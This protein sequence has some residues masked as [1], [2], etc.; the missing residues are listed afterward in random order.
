[1][2]N[3]PALAASITFSFTGVVSDVSPSL[4]TSG[5]NFNANQTLSGSYTFN[6][7]TSDSNPSPNIGQYNNAITALTVNV[8]SYSA[9]LGSSGANFITIRN[10]SS[11]QYLLRAPLTGPLANGFSPIQFCI[12]L[13]D[14]SGTVFVNSALPTSPP[15]LSAFAS[16]RFEL[17]SRMGM[18]PRESLAP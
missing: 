16:D 10:Q 14:P 4:F 8:G 18:G 11:D 15:S 3:T 7:M 9:T 1:M 17:F 6:S 12:A 5:G 13:V 2:A